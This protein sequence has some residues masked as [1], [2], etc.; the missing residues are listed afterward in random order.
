M[1]VKLSG[2][3]CDDVE[4]KNEDKDKRTDVRRTDSGPHRHVHGLD[5]LLIAV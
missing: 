3:E 4:D 5:T 2:L 1:G